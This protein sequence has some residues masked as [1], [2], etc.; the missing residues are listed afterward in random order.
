[1]YLKKTMIFKYLKD[2]KLIA[3]IV[4]IILF[5]FILYASFPFLSAFFG[6]GILAFIFHPLDKK[7]RKY[8]SPAL[9]AS[10]ILIITLILIIVPIIFIINGLI[11]QI[12]LLPKQVEKLDVLTQKINEAFPF[13]IQIDEKKVINEVV[14][15][16]KNSLKPAIS[17]IIHAFIILFLLFFLLF[18]LL[19]YY[20]NIVKLAIDNLPFTKENNLKILHKLKEITYATIIGTFLIAIIQGGLL[21]FNFYAFGIPNAIFWGIVTTILCFIPFVGAPIIWIPASIYLLITEQTAK[22]VAMIFIGILIS[23]I[24]NILRPIINQRFGSIHPLVSI[25]GIFIGISQF[26]ALGIFIGPILVVYF[27]LFYD[28]YSQEYFKKN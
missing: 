28:I 18:Y 9:S 27:L 24:D 6:A 7:L 14:S 26:G 11:D 5:I 10:I 12:S 23:T 16:L 15:I 25:I 21:A 8:F 13:N 17:N 4:I 19:I 1:M 3:E 2:K 22:G 20:D